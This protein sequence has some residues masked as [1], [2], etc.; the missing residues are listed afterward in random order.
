[1]AATRIRHVGRSQ[2]AEASPMRGLRNPFGYRNPVRQTAL[3]VTTGW[4][5]HWHRPCSV[6]WRHARAMADAHAFFE[7]PPDCGTTI[8]VNSIVSQPGKLAGSRQL[9]QLTFRQTACSTRREG[10]AHAAL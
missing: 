8:R 10:A 4:D 9:I 1:M 3:G 7:F 2:T 5:V 6:I